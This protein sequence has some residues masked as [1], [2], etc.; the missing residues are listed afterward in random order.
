MTTRLRT[1]V[2]FG[3]GAI[4]AGL[5][6]YEAHRS[7]NFG[8][9]VAAEVM[10]DVVAAVRA[11]GGR[12]GLNV[13]T[14]DGIERREV[15]GVEILNPRA[16]A[17]RAELVAAVA[18]ASEMATALPSVEFYG[19]ASD[20][21]SVAAII[22]EGA[23]QG[24]GRCIL[25]AAENHNRAA[26]ILTG[27]LG[28]AAAPERLLCV[29]TVIGKMSGVADDREQIAR[30]SLAPVAPGIE[31]CFLVEE[32]SRILVGKVRWPD[33]AR[34]IDVFEERADLRPFEEAKLYGHNA[35]HALIGYLGRAKGH[36]TVAEAGADAE[37]MTFARDAFIEESGAA[38]C[39]RHAG[40]DPLFTAAG[41]KAYADDL[42]ARMVNPHLGDTIARVTRDPRRKLGWDDRLIG[43]VRVALAEG[44][45]PLR[46]AKA[47]AA[48][49]EVLGAKGRAAKARLL[50]EIWPQAAPA[51]E[52]GRVK[53]VIC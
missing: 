11:N 6:L 28:P 1:F 51:D 48:A 13:A 7:R 52:A 23:G 22:A 38:L 4:Q 16:P 44:I 8:R 29:D 5:F 25:Y 30:Q 47:A 12:Y 35:T 46:Y 18:E 50:D 9:L 40:V 26:E 2:G 24:A 31:R 34:G 19:R 15:P 14:R 42:L 20:T 21:A 32:F 3:F 10:P 37:L 33:C 49:L 41:Y 27:A 17:D 45:E 43:T 39:R 53:A 36:T